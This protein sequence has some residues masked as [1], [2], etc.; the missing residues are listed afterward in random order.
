[1]RKQQDNAA[2]GRNSVG[3]AACHNMVHNSQLLGILSC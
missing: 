2:R 1:M 3:C